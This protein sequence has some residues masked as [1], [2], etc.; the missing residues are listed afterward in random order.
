MQVLDGTVLSMAGFRPALDVG[1]HTEDRET[2][3]PKTLLVRQD[4]RS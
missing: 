2:N 1:V 3:T 4:G